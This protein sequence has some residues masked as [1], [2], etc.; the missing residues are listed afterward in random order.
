MEVRQKMNRDVYLEMVKLLRAYEKWEGDLVLCAEAWQ[1]PTGL[2][3]LTQELHDRLIE[4]Q[5]RRNVV[6]AETVR[7]G[8]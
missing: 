1:T 7:I 4:L 6:L 3:M 2:P 8:L 5:L